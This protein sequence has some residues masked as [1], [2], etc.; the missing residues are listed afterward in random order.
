MGGDHN[1][2]TRKC[3]LRQLQANHVGLLRREI[4]ILRKGLHEVIELPAV[5][6][7]KPLLGSHHLQVGCLGHAV[8]PGDQA[9]TI[10]HRFLCLHHIR[11]H[12]QHR[13]GGLLLVSD[14]GE[15]SHQLTSFV[16]LRIAAQRSAYLSI[17]SSPRRTVI[18]P[19]FASVVS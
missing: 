15:G 8:T 2:V 5:R 7:L 12:T 1:L 9:C 13:T 19:M 16:N 18:R 6:F 4:I 17:S 10:L 3:P 11:Q 14:C